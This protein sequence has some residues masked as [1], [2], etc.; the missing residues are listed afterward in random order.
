M[1]NKN[2]TEFKIEIQ[3]DQ[4]QIEYM[5]KT[6]VRMCIKQ[7]VLSLYAFDSIEIVRCN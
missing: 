4:T 7:Y 1:I 6:T 5:V 3:S 2:Y